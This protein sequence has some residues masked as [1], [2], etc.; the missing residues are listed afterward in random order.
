M[1]EEHGYMPEKIGCMLDEYDYLLEGC[2]Y[3]LEEHF[4]RLIIDQERIIF[5][6]YL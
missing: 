6:L 2:G 4:V 5:T 1:V 3:M